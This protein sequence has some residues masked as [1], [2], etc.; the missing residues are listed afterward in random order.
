MPSPQRANSPAQPARVVL[1]PVFS[2]PVVTTRGGTYKKAP[3]VP[4]PRGKKAAAEP[5]A[6]DPEAIPGAFPAPQQPPVP[7][8]SGETAPEHEAGQETSPPHTGDGR[9]TPP[10]APS[11]DPVHPSEHS[12]P[13]VSPLGWS[14]SFAQS[15]EVDESLLDSP[16]SFRQSTPVIPTTF[17]TPAASSPIENTP[18]ASPIRTPGSPLRDPSPTARDKAPETEPPPAPDAPEP[19]A[20][21]PEPPKADESVP[22]E[23]D[24]PWSS[25]SERI[26]EAK[27]RAAEQAAQSTPGRRNPVVD[28]VLGK[29]A[30][31]SLDAYD[32]FS[33]TM[34]QQNQ[35]LREL[36]GA[37]RDEINA[38]SDRNTLDIINEV[39]E[40]YNAFV[41]ENSNERLATFEQL[42][43]ILSLLSH[44][45]TGFLTRL[46]AIQSLLSHISGRQDAAMTLL[47]QFE[48]KVSFGIETLKHEIAKKLD[49]V[50]ELSNKR[51]DIGLG[52]LEKRLDMTF[53]DIEKSQTARFAQL[54][55]SL[56]GSANARAQQ[57]YDAVTNEVK[58]L[59]HE[60]AKVS[61][62]QD[63]Y[64][65]E[66]LNRLSSI[67]AAVVKRNGRECPC[68]YN[69]TTAPRESP[70]D[71]RRDRHDHPPHLHP[72]AFDRTLGHQK[73]EPRSFF[74]DPK[75]STTPPWPP[76]RAPWAV[77]QA[78][79]TPAPAPIPVPAPKVHFPT[80]PVTSFSNGF[81]MF[82]PTALGSVPEEERPPSVPP[83]SAPPLAPR[84]DP[85]AVPAPTL[86][87]TPAPP[88]LSYGPPVDPPPPGFPNGAPPPPPP[89]FP[90][91]APPPPPSGP[92]PNAPL[93]PEDPHRASQGLG[94]S[95]GSQGPTG[96]VYPKV[97][98]L[99]KF[100]ARKGEDVD[101]WI[102][103]LT[104][105]YQQMRVPFD[106]LL[107]N[108]PMLLTG[109]ARDWITT[110]APETR[111]AYLTWDQWSDAM[112]MEFREANYLAKKGQELRQCVWKTV[113]PS[114]SQEDCIQ[115]LLSG[116][117]A[118]FHPH[119]KSGMVAEGARTLTTFRRVLIDLEPSLN[120]K[121]APP[122]RERF[123]PRRNPSSGPRARFSSAREGATA[124]S[125][126]AP[127]TTSGDQ[128][129]RVG[130]QQASQSNQRRY[131]PGSGSAPRTGQPTT[132]SGS[133]RPARTYA[134]DAAEEREEPE[135]AVDVHDDDEVIR[136]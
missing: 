56:D 124:T 119:L 43:T 104:A 12:I 47:T 3:Y 2:T 21:V 67:E 85:P 102:A 25:F 17:A 75:D 86:G 107:S 94:W 16:K 63:H 77:P 13:A 99:P 34:T 31:S 79:P 103:K 125:S 57:I 115:D 20:Q 26:S 100:S 71:D 62:M 29:I 54:V 39:V 109:E 88:Y 132:H 89:G 45:D 122:P 90:G 55:S 92:T 42:T 111:A 41:D 136:G 66:I 18:R 105:I 126:P 59:K 35:W 97:R 72:G 49:S 130:A 60:P 123:D 101:V 7:P 73:P 128:K 32:L 70:D 91:G 87:A 69:R 96:Q 134:A 44:E 93:A 117:P 9:V 27:R 38:N 118:E 22:H 37:L 40:S 106:H 84:A 30:S 58:N 61:Y 50:S 120:K 15:R 116:L 46:D 64:T 81:P 65:N 48:Q 8:K 1:E 10:R 24:D 129:P 51:F 36:A 19:D 14:S 112:R 121:P 68:L 135:D 108:L 82:V 11:N 76:S 53:D 33:T 80:V 133:S 78:L 83:A 110:L 52:S 98:D 131:T 74:V 95:T 114:A 28:Q 6:S 23:S 127:R 113:M 5:P 4:K